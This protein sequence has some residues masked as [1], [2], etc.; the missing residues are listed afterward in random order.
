MALSYGFKKNHEPQAGKIQRKPSKF[1][2]EK[3]PETKD[4]EKQPK[5]GKHALFSNQQQ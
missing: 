1:I 3:W 5:R 2:T 4:K